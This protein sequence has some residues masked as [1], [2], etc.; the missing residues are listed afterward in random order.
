MLK[1]IHGKS[2]LRKIDL[3]DQSVKSLLLEAAGKIQAEGW[4]K[5]AL[6][7]LKTTTK[8]QKLLKAC[9]KNDGDNLGI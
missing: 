4:M 9:I 2:E 7:E 5:F 6:R 3:D 1:S 8:E